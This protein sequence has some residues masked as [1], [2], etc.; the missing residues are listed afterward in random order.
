MSNNT[1]QIRRNLWDA[2]WGYVESF[3][4]GIGLMLT[5]FFLEI[6]SSGS[7]DFTV[8]YPYNLYFLLGYVGFLLILYFGFRNTQV[9]RWLTKVPASISS[10]VLITFLVMIMGIVPQIPSE[11]NIITNLGLNKI[12]SNWAFLLVLFQFLTCLGLI[13]IK[14]IV[15]FKT[16]NI[17]FILNHLGLFLALVA[18]MLGTGDLQRLSL[19]TFENKHSWVATDI[20]NKEVELPFAVYLNEFLIEEYN[21]KLA[22][23]DNVSGEVVENDGKNLYLINKDEDYIYKNYQVNVEKFHTSSGRIGDR[24]MPVSDIGSPPSAYLS[25]KNIENDSIVKGWISCGSFAHPYQSL[26]LDSKYSFVMT[27]P[28]AKKFS[29]DIDIVS[30]EG[31]KTKT[32]L[33]V[34]KPYKYNGWKLYQLSY[35]E[36][37]GK[38]S[39]LSV[40]E[41]VRDPWLPVIYTGIFMMIAGAFYMFW[42][43]NK[44]TKN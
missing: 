4:I 36:K 12:T 17:G 21:P 23:I 26:K 6:S 40:I 18:G 27:I 1:T 7:L 19:N 39:K 22:L 44:I 41:L 33:E 37:M 38:W 31:D 5:G 43:G 8:S 3:F 35:N 9:V 20:N 11:N 15:Q 14:R 28:E 25:V 32:V 30:K 42:V 10:I 24:Y 13:T 2:P 16:E 29:S 34:N